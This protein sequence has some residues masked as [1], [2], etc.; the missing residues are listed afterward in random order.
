MAEEKAPQHVTVRPEIDY[1]YRDTFNVFFGFEEI[2]IE[3]GNRSRT[4]E[5]EVTV[6]DRVVLSIANAQRL[7]Q[8]LG[9]GL[10]G[11]KQKLEEQ[12]RQAMGAN[13]PEGLQ[14]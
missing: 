6:G 12:Q 1:V 4:A 14:G 3:F 13:T 10:T 8:A 5:N 7:Q 2:I 9:Q 11:L